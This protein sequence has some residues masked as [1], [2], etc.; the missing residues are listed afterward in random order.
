MYLSVGV[1]VQF[2]IYPCAYSLGKSKES[3]LYMLVWCN[4]SCTYS[5]R[6]QSFYYLVRALSVMISVLRIPTD[7][8]VLYLY[9][10]HIFV[11]WISSYQFTMV[12]GCMQRCLMIFKLFISIILFF[13][14]FCTVTYTL[15]QYFQSEF[16]CYQVVLS[17]STSNVNL[18]VSSGYSFFHC[19][20]LLLVYKFPVTVPKRYW[21]TVCAIFVFYFSFYLSFLIL[22]V[23]ILLF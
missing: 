20:S 17:N 7:P 9:A 14:V 18:P 5:C 10:T 1:C 13:Y 12:W 8:L 2:I 22:E 21:L 3:W 15:L 16:T 6:M 19:F 11:R 4:I 23:R